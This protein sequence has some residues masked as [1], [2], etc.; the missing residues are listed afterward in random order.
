MGKGLWARQF[1]A[2]PPC[3]QRL[4][5]TLCYLCH[6]WHLCCLH[7][8]PPRWV[9]AGSGVCQCAASPSCWWLALTSVRPPHR[10]AAS[11]PPSPGLAATGAGCSGWNIPPA[12]RAGTGLRREG[13]SLA[14]PPPPPPP[15]L[16]LQQASD[17]P[18]ARF[19]SSPHPASRPHSN[20]SSFRCLHDG[21]LRC[22]C[23]LS[24]RCF[25]QL[26]V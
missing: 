10:R 15:Q 20:V 21:A 16:G 9:G 11:P 17:A 22:V 4:P 8:G 6:P 5:A 3:N 7:Q 24:G 23:V 14:Q 19:P 12:C 26:L 18:S 13:R 1:P 2:L 25:F